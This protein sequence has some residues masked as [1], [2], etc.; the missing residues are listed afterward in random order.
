MHENASSLVSP[1]IDGY[2][3]IALT[4][5]QKNGLTLEHVSPECKEYR[6][7]ALAAL[8][9]NFGALEHIPPSSEYDEMKTTAK[10]RRD[11][12][13]DELDREKSIDALRECI[14]M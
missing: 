6:E 2:L 8:E 12:L 10:K 11:K 4:P 5:V 7:I 9:Q 1:S 14:V 13:N 3:K